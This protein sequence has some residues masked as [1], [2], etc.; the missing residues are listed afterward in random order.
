MSIHADLDELI[1]VLAEA[2]EGEWRESEAAEGEAHKQ[3][4]RRRLMAGAERM[5]VTAESLIRSLMLRDYAATER[6]L[7]RPRRPREW[8]DLALCLAAEAAG[9]QA[10]RRESRAA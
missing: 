2:L 3:V 6:L 4:A 5:T 1:A 7:A 9:G 8:R 10:A